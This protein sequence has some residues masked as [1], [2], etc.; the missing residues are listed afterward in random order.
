VKNDASA[1]IPTII[2]E[3]EEEVSVT[4]SLDHL[5][6]AVK[7]VDPEIIT[8]YTVPFEESLESTGDP[9]A[10]RKRPLEGQSKCTLGFEGQKGEHFD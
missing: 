5:P 8:C 3:P 10:C 2:F 6:P 7:P 9:N 4:P 1:S